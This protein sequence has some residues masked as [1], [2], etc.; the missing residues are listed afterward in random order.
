MPRRHPLHP[1]RGMSELDAQIAAAEQR[2]M[3]RQRQLQQRATL[4][5]VRVRKA[6]RPGRFAAPAIGAAAAGAAL[7][8]TL[9]RAR[10]AP[11]LTL[12]AGWA[13]EAGL[14]LLRQ[15]FTTRE[16]V[17]PARR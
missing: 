13:L 14:P 12:L 5:G 10:R 15:R 2:L 4:I 16:P 3:E 11:I 8:W 7:W 9:R 17:P 6:L 1:E